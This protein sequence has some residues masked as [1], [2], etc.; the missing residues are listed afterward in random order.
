[1]HKYEIHPQRE[2][3]AIDMEFHFQEWLDFLHVHVYGRALQ[4]DDFIFPSVNLKGLVQPGS[5]ISH[6]TIQKWLDEFVAAAG[7]KIGYGQLTT[8]CF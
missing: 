7:V 1:G 4:G 3:P 6:D 5:P 2:M 8:H